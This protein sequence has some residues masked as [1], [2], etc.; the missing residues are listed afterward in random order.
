MDFFKYKSFVLIFGYLSVILQ[1]K[2]FVRVVLRR[3]DV[4]GNYKNQ[5][6]VNNLIKYEKNYLSAFFPN[7]YLWTIIEVSA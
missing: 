2:R 6:F 3:T 4:G 1:D 7:L 5:V